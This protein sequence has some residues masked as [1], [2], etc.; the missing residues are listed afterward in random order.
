MGNYSFAKNVKPNL[1]LFNQGKNISWVRTS[2]FPIKSWKQMFFWVMNGHTN[3]D[4]Y[5]IYI[6][7]EPDPRRDFVSGFPG[8]TR[9]TRT[10]PTRAESREVLMKYTMVLRAIMPFI[11]NILIFQEYFHAIQF[12]RSCHGILDFWKILKVESIIY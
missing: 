11:Y 3:R 5:S 12:L 8:C 7:T 10:R 9:I 1:E 2:S 6:D 4:Y